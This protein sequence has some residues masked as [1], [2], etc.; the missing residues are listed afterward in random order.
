MSNYKTQEQIKVFQALPMYN[1]HPYLSLKNMGKKV[2]IK[3]GKMR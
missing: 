1:M 3:H 2:C